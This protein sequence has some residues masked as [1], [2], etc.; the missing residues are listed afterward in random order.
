MGVCGVRVVEVVD[1]GLGVCDEV[2]GQAPGSKVEP[3]EGVTGVTDS[4][5]LDGA[6]GCAAT[7]AGSGAEDGAG[8]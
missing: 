1:G 4:V 7:G 2:A 6:Q 5:E 3:A 8:G